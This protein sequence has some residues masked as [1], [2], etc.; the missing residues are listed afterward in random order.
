MDSMQRY[1]LKDAKIVM[2]VLIEGEPEVWALDDYASADHLEDYLIAQDLPY[3][4]IGVF[5]K[6]N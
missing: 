4:I 2:V 1:F 5:S 6:F 3:V